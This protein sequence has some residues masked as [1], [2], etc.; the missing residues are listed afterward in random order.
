M[1]KYLKNNCFQPFRLVLGITVLL[2][3]TFG[4]SGLQRAIAQNVLFEPNQ[5]NCDTVD[6]RNPVL[7]PSGNM[8]TVAEYC[9]SQ[10][11][12]RS[13]AAPSVPWG[14]TYWM[15]GNVCRDRRNGVDTI[16]LTPSSATN[17]RWNY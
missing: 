2:M 13:D 9:Q 5:I 15:D 1:C 4:S 6:G 11:Q 10:S 16:C 8:I 12:R 7:L 17:L 14:N 3:E